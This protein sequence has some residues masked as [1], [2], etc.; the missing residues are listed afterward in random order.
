MK[1]AYGKLVWLALTIFILAFLFMPMRAGK[2]DHMMI[3]PG[4]LKMSVGDSYEIKSVISA[5]NTNQ[6]VRYSS[7][8]SKVASISPS[9]KVHALASG[10]TVI[11][12][13]ASGGAKAEMKVI[14]VGVPMSYLELN[15]EELIIAKG[16]FSGLSVSYNWDASDTRLQWISADESVATVDS[17]GRI[18]GVGG[19]TTYISVIAPNGLT[20]SVKVHVEVE[21]VAAH[22]SPHDITVGVGAEVPLKVMFLPLDCTDTVRRWTSSDSS[23]ASVNADGVLV[24]H[25]EGRAY[26]GMVSSGG[27]SAGMEVVV[28]AAPKDMQLNPAKA[29]LERGETLAMQVLFTDDAGV[30]SEN[31]T[32]LAV[33]S[34]DHPE[35][36]EVDQN[37]VVTAKA[38][39]SARITAKVDGLTA[40]CRVNVEVG[41][42]KIELNYD[43]MDLLREDTVNPIQL[44]WTYSPLDPDDATIRFESSNTQVANVS[45]AGLVTFTGGYG[46]AEIRAYAASGAEAVFTVNVVTQLPES[47]D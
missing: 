36:A 35:I 25:S 18:M 37:G 9:G 41:I 30:T 14:V 6:R 11:R 20:D 1:T 24:A 29:T 7:D 26:I 45:S 40:V 21:G 10:E 33:W 8:D 42:Q 16:Q 46:T 3:S 12:A 15:A 44:S 32:H 22:I 39:G 38:S 2:E 5:D 13:E 17:S 34:S 43:S 28:E 27:L 31:N 4:T 23:V 19:G 47:G